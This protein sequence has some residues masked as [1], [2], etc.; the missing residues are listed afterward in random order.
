[1][2]KTYTIGRS[3]EADITLAENDNGQGDVIT[4]SSMHADLMVSDDGVY[5]L[6]D[7]GS[8]NGTYVYIGDAWKKVSKNSRL[9]TGA[10]IKLGDY[11]ISLSELLDVVPGDP[12]DLDRITPKNAVQNSNHG[13]GIREGEARSRPGDSTFFSSGGIGLSSVIV[14]VTLVAVWWFAFEKPARAEA[15]LFAG[16]S[17]ITGCETYLSAYSSGK[18]SQAARSFIRTAKDDEGYRQCSSIRGCESYLEEF[19]SGRHV[20]SARQRLERFEREERERLDSLAHRYAKSAG[21][22]IVTSLGGGQDIHTRVHSWTHNRVEGKLEIDMQVNFNGAL[23]RTNDYWVRGVLTVDDNGRNPSFARR[24]ANQRL[25]DL[26]NMYTW[27]GIGVI[28]LMA[29]Q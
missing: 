9:G 17:S 14:V 26:E 21:R 29:L 3:A 24:S 19:P 12:L 10:R 22:Q 1:M 4:V 6:T 11:E 16:C 27:L 7:K 15:E 28:S 5:Y 8:T 25:R 13:P 23:W 2:A 18:H 20:A